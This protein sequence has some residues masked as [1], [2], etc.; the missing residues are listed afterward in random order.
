MQLAKK[1]KISSLRFPEGDTLGVIFSFLSACDLL[2]RG[3]FFIVCKEWYRV[4]CKLSHAWGDELDLAWVD[5]HIP[6]TFPFAW[7]RVQRLHI[8]GIHC[9]IVLPYF[10]MVPLRHL[11]ID[12]VFT[13][14]DLSAMSSLQSLDL[15][16]C[17]NISDDNLALF[18]M[19]PVRKLI[20]TR[21]FELTDDGLI[22]LKAMPLEWLEAK[23]CHVSDLGLA[24]LSS[25]PLRHL[26]L[27]GC[28]HVTDAGLVHLARMPLQ[29]LNLSWCHALTGVGFVHLSKMPLQH[30]SLFGCSGVTDGCLSHLALLPLQH[31]DLRYCSQLTDAGLPH[32]SS[33]PL[34]YLSLSECFQITD[35]GLTHISSLRLR[36]LFVTNCMLTGASLVLLESMPLHTFHITYRQF[37]TESITT[38]LSKVQSTLKNTSIF[39]GYSQ[40]RSAIRKRFPQINI[41]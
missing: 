11:R 15:R 19:L 29:Y 13:R 40:V 31:L 24:H 5:S 34:Q 30:L 18:A 25:L 2:L 26:D 17:C 35:A 38:F 36:H 8:R 4:L 37:T 27:S 10:S 14:I 39:G 22:H 6:R 12:G 33:M 1:R 20:L 21:W 41:V 32:L 7:H 9:C 16:M 23:W 3:G 28:T